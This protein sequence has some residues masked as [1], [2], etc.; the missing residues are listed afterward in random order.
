MAYMPPTVNA[1]PAPHELTPADK[2]AVKKSNANVAV[3]HDE[4]DFK[5][6]ASQSQILRASHPGFNH[7][8]QS[9]TPISC[10]PRLHA[11][12]QHAAVSHAPV[13]I[14]P[15]TQTEFGTW[16]ERPREADR[17]RKSEDDK[18]HKLCQLVIFALMCACRLVCCSLF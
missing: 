7:I 8:S 13:A 18:L 11:A 4:K 5:Y 16:V 9:S 1:K 17:P 15:R 2:T 12:S 14:M 10:T 6:L 3:A